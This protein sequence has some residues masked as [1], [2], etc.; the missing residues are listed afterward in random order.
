M[1]TLN[2]TQEQYNQLIEYIKPNE[3]LT[4]VLRINEENDI[5]NDSLAIIRILSNNEYEKYI[6]NS[7]FDDSVT[8]RSENIFH[9]CQ[10]KDSCLMQLQHL[11]INAAGVESELVDYVF[12]ALKTKNIDLDKYKNKL[13]FKTNTW[14]NKRSN[15]NMNTFF[16]LTES[17]TTNTCT[18]FCSLDLRMI[19][20]HYNGR[21]T[22]EM[23]NWGKKY[24]N[25]Y[26]IQYMNSIKTFSKNDTIT[27]YNG[28]VYNYNSA[29]QYYVDFTFNNTICFRP[30]FQY[31][32]NNKSTN[33]FK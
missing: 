11:Y 17:T 2:L 26:F 3:E 14:N 12:A 25:H 32:D 30:A 20:A 22:S 7:N 33:I 27:S 23:T 8:K 19:I 28:K 9:F 18:T 10:G 31:I 1:P 15:F 21:N 24:S 5:S 6:I 4:N 13:Y 29:Y 16:E